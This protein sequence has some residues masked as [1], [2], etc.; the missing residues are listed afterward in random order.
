M[1]N[2][3]KFEKVSFDQFMNDIDKYAEDQLRYLIKEDPDFIR[4]TIYD[5]IILP[6]R[7]TKGS[8]GY[9]FFM[10]FSDIRIFPGESIVIPTGIKVSILN[11]WYL[12][13]CPKSGLSFKFPLRLVDT[14]AIIDADYYNNSNN[15]GHIIAKITNESKTKLCRL[16]QGDK[17]IQGIFCEYGIVC[18]DNADGIRN[19]GFG[20]TSETGYRRYHY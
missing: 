8:A 11:E 13:L 12:K 7:S 18:G 14:V 9:D 20:S 10:P 5:K 1:K 3:G 4:Y 2:V 6:S 19:G 15:E 17:Y 16:D